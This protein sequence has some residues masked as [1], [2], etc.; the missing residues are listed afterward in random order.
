M[1]IS[2]KEI[3]HATG[4]PAGEERNENLQPARDIFSMD[5]FNCGAGRHKKKMRVFVV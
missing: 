4:L 3:T 5:C 1:M 2:L